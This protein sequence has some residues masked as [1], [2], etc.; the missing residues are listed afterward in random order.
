MRTQFYWNFRR[1]NAV[2]IENKNQEQPAWLDLELFWGKLNNMDM[3]DVIMARIIYVVRG[4]PGYLVLKN[5][6]KIQ[7]FY[8]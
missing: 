7:T 6:N 5:D 2:F 8:I 3:V 1:N 4:Y